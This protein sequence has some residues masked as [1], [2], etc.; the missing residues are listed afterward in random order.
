MK[1]KG[2]VMD[3]AQNYPTMIIPNGTE[4]GVNEQGQLSIRTPGNLVLQ[5]SGVYSVIE[6]ASGSVRI[7]PQVTVEA[8]SVQAAES[9]FVAGELTAWRVK[10]SKITLEKGAKANIML[11][12]SDALE[13][14]RNARLVGNFSSE[15]EMYLTLGRFSRQLRHLPQGLVS[16]EGIPKGLPEEEPLGGGES[17]AAKPL[18]EPFISP[19]GEDEPAAAEREMRQE[20]QE[21]LSLVRVVIE[22]ELGRPTLSVAACQALERMLE[23]VRSGDLSAIEEAYR[24][25]ISQVNEASE[26]LENAREMLDRMFGR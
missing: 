7:D 26:D 8:V 1:A 6:S 23:M 2:E 16:G 9:C 12:E 17:P 5:N 20:R 15:K 24:Y 13:L 11:Q 21:I 4:I 14:D 19:D 18:G 10:A 22:R 3:E 25:L